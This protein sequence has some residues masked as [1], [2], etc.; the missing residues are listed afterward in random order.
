MRT[1]RESISEAFKAVQVRAV[2]LVRFLEIHMFRLFC[3]LF[4]VY[5]ALFCC[6]FLFVV[7]KMCGNKLWKQL[8]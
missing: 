8:Y 7:F 4:I 5:I 2:V 6:C 3:L 1:L